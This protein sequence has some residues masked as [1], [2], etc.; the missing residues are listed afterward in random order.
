MS[1]NYRGFAADRF[2]RRCVFVRLRGHRI[3]V[4]IRGH[5]VAVRFRGRGE[6]VDA[7]DLKSLSRKAVRVRIP[8]SAPALSR[9]WPPG[10][11]CHYLCF[12]L[13]APA[14]SK[15]RFQC[16]AR[17]LRALQSPDPITIK[18]IPIANNRRTAPLKEPWGFYGVRRGEVIPGSP[19]PNGHRG[20][21]PQGG[22]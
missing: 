7:R 21:R 4:R 17:R 11:I 1:C 16:L 18:G 3:V 22:C 14:S 15:A 10:M 13:T 19:R 12:Y 5:C 9:D 2:R 20:R 8:P 6:M